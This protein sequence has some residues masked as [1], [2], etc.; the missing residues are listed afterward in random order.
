MI[1][2]EPLLQEYEYATL[3]TGV[4]GA[5]ARDGSLTYARKARAS[6]RKSKGGVNPVKAYDY[7]T[8]HPVI[9]RFPSF[10]QDRFRIPLRQK[11]GISVVA[12]SYDPSNTPIFDGIRLGVAVSSVSND[13]LTTIP[14]PVDL[15]CLNPLNLRPIRKTTYL[16]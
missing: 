15:N 10:R 6:C 12:E 2:L 8:L 14:E 3:S 11:P 9:L 13:Y 7:L 4:G 1:L 5:V 16:Q